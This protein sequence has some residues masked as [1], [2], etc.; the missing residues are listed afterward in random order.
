M[1]ER[2]ILDTKLD[3]FFGMLDA[4]DDGGIRESDVVSLATKLNAAV[5]ADDPATLARL[6][7]ALG[8]VWSRDLKAMDTDGNGAIDAEEYR[9]GVRRSLET[10]ADGFLGRMG[11]LMQEWTTLCDTDGNGVLD[12]EEYAAM[13]GKTFGVPR[14]KLDEAFSK[15]D[16]NGDGVLSRDE[17][18][19]AALQYFTSE[20][21][22][23]P[24]NWLFGSA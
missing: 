10:D 4:D 16:L 2:T 1:P 11:T 22:D 12:R 6:R 5:G 19:A 7:D 17:I 21:P 18:S 15:L 23:A 14:Q 8:A 13:Y 20:E 24:G 9:V 3:R